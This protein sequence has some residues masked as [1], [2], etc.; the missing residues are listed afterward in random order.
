MFGDD[1]EWPVYCPNCG[2][3]T[4]KRIGWLLANTRLTCEG[5]GATL[6]YYRERMTRDL[7]DAQRAVA[8]FSKGLRVEKSAR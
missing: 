7:E 4:C 5:C 8:N 6:A 1:D 3:M 2:A